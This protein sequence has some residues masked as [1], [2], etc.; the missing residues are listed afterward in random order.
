MDGDMLLQLLLSDLYDTRTVMSRASHQEWEIPAFF[1]S[2]E[3]NLICVGYPIVKVHWPLVQ[4]GQVFIH[5]PVLWLTTTKNVS[6]NV[7]LQARN[8]IVQN[9]S[10]RGIW[11]THDNLVIRPGFQSWVVAI[12]QIRGRCGRLHWGSNHGQLTDK[13]LTKRKGEKQRE[14]Q[15]PETPKV[16]NPTTGNLMTLNSK[17]Q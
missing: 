1:F 5:P 7:E 6:I 15:G 4:R 13:P 9:V 14:T 17:L 8:K 2:K 10:L 16:Q 3:T 11:R 12:R